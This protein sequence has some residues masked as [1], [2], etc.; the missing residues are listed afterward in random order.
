MPRFDPA[1]FGRL[2][3]RPTPQERRMAEGMVAEAR[4]RAAAARRWPGCT[5]PT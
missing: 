5:A 2:L 1:A 4:E 3:A